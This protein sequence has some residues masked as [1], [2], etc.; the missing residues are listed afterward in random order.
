MMR[1]AVNAVGNEVV[2]LKRLQMGSLKLD[3]SLACGEY[4]PLSEA[5]IHALKNREA[6][7]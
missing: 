1:N 4:R 7:L 6:D 5:E 2:Y 3:E